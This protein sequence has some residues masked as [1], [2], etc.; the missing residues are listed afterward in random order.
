MIPLSPEAPPWTGLLQSFLKWADI[1]S[2]AQ[3]TLGCE[4]TSSALHTEQAGVLGDRG[5]RG[6]ESQ[7]DEVVSHPRVQSMTSS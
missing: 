6:G 1:P 2:R 5:V 3:G 7:E 4:G